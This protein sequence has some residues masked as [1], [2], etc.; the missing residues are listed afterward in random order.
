MGFY[1]PT[2]NPN[3]MMMENHKKK[4]FQCIIICQ[5]DLNIA[6][7][8]PEEIL[9]ADFWQKGANKRVCNHDIER[10]FSQDPTQPSGLLG[11]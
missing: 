6:S 10:I 7:S 11:L 8:T 4:S 2:E 5:D 1:P 9:H 3:V